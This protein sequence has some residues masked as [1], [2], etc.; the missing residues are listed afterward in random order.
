MPRLTCISA[1]HR[2]PKLVWVYCPG[3]AGVEGNDK[4]DRLA[5]KGTT[6]NGLRL[7]RSEVLRSL[8][9]YLWAQSLGHH[10]IDRLKERGME[11]KSARLSSLKGSE[12]AIVNQTNIGSVSKAIFGYD[13]REGDERMRAFPIT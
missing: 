1:R 8:R 9:H 12:K 11:R 7:G 5:G 2:L 6:T 3:H 4:A 13:L 10:A